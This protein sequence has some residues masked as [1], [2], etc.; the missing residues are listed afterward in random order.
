MNI[1]EQRRQ[2]GDDIDQTEVAMDLT[3][4]AYGRQPKHV[5]QQE[6]SDN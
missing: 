3:L 5:F 4:S 2:T 1:Q 6:V